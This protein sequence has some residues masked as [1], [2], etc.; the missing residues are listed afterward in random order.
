MLLFLRLQLQVRLLPDRRLTSATVLCDT[1]LMLFVLGGGEG[2]G[3]NLYT[4]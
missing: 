4:G 2:G 3:G 1:G